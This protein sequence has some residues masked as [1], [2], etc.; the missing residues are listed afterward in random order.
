MS[1][2]R[3]ILVG[4]TASAVVAPA[5]VRGQGAAKVVVVGGGFGG[6]TCARF[7][8]GLAPDMA[9]TL[10]EANKTYTACP[11][12]NEVI[13]GL[14]GIGQQQFGYDGIA[15]AGVTVASV[16]A[17]AVDPGART[18]TLADGG[19]LSY[20]RLVVA[21]GIDF[22]W[23]ALPGYDEAAAQRMPH[24]WK[25]GEQTVLL[26]RQLEAM[27]DGGLVVISA[28][29]TPYRCP[30]A[31]YERASLIAHSL[32]ASKPRSKVLVL[33]AKDSFSQQPLFQKAWSEL[34]PGLI[35]WVSLSQGGNVISVE[36]ATLTVNTDFDKHKADVANIIPPQK[37]GGLAR[38]AGVADRTGWC[39]VE[40]V[41]FA[42]TLQPDIHVLGDAALMGA[43]PKA[44]F[45]A[46]AQGQVCA[47]AI[48]ASLAGQPAPD[49]RLISTCYNLVAPDYGFSL[50]GVYRPEKG[51]LL[52]V[53]GAGGASPIDGDAALRAQ[54]ARYADD[55]F[56]ATTAQ[57]FG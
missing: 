48:V 17:T 34:Y 56:R 30:P 26:R 42:S 50:V 53:P 28:P 13:A 38:L 9:V 10:V 29:A 31:P 7:L 11:F 54:E 5:I 6:A 49:S 22:D 47:A 25:A 36:P 24:A 14:R 45:S 39:P 2:R 12:S 16:A 19:K 8:K 4:L 51:Q 20:D 55:W 1:T 33:D 44:A 46:S 18:V 15:R 3:R 35:E 21:P 52:E 37:A 23:A 40:P 27:A 57:I 41:A 43:M 32:K